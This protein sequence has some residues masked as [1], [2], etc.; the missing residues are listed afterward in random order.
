LVLISGLSDT[1][2][3]EKAGAYRS[4]LPEWRSGK[5]K[6]YLKKLPQIAAALGVKSEE[7]L[8][9]DKNAPELKRRRLML[10][11]N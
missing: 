10:I 5:T 3:A 1:D 8:D 2:F 4:S 6:S 9:D 11:Y 7:L